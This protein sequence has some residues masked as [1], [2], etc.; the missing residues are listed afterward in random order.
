MSFGKKHYITNPLL[1]YVI[2]LMPGTTQDKSKVEISQ[3]FVAFSEHMNITCSANKSHIAVHFPMLDASHFERIIF[4]IISLKVE[5]SYWQTAWGIS[6]T[7][8]QLP[9]HR[10]YITEISSNSRIKYSLIFIRQNQYFDMFSMIWHE[11]VMLTKIF[12]F[13]HLLCR[14]ILRATVCKNW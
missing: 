11:I 12:L 2:I 6:V 13:R 8:E 3:N 1:K 5:K 10:L 7:L 9:H 4:G 14:T